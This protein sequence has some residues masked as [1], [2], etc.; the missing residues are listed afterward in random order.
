MSSRCCI[1]QS[2]HTVCFLP[3]FC[4]LTDFQTSMSAHWGLIT[5]ARLRFAQT[6]LALINATAQP[7]MQEMVWNVMMWTNAYWAPMIAT[8]ILFVPTPSVTFLASATVVFVEMD[9]L[10]AQMWMNAL[11][12][13]TTVMWIQTAPI[14]LGHFFVCASAGMQ[15]MVQAAKVSKNVAPSSAALLIVMFTLCTISLPF[16]QMCACTEDWKSHFSK[17]LSYKQVQ[18]EMLVS[19]LNAE[20]ALFI[21]A[22]MHGVPSTELISVV[23]AWL[24]S[25]D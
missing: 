25:I 11:K 6:S 2:V 17:C 21:H 18:S 5:A 24:E 15:R 23:N 9:V 3:F 10:S 20:L 12:R 19:C 16:G 14:R 7:A 8:E 22:W 13:L 1:R 4:E